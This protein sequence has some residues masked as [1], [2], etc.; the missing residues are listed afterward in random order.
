M[1]Q[2]KS[3]TRQLTERSGHVHGPQNGVYLAGTSLKTRTRCD[4]VLSRFNKLLIQRQTTNKYYGIQ[5][6]DI[7]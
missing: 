7:T 1:P 6:T 5:R 4:T 2:Q 3:Q